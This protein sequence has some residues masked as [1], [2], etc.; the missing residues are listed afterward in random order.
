MK[1]MSVVLAVAV[2]LAAAPAARAET[3]WSQSVTVTGADLAPAAPG[4]VPVLVLGA[5]ES[6]VLTDAVMT[7]TRV[8]QPYTYRVYIRRGEATNEVPCDV[9]SRVLT[10]YVPAAGTASINL[11][12]GLL[13][14]PGE[15]ICLFVDGASGTDGIAFD[16]IGVKLP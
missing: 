13:F 2:A 4:G 6:V 12:T 1:T 14:Q 9:A 5:D 16:L 11:S 3:H 15:Q 7:Q 10:S 8:Y